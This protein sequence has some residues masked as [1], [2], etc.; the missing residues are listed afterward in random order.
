MRY[1][2]IT[3]TKD[4]SD[5]MAVADPLDVLFVKGDEVNR[6]L[7]ANLLSKYVRLDEK[8]RIFPLS[9]FYAETNKNK[10]IIILLSRK[11]ISLKSGKEEAASPSELSNVID[12]P[13]GSLRP[14]LRELVEEGIADDESSKYK[15]FSHTIQRCSE[16][17]TKKEPSETPIILRKQGSFPKTSMSAAIEDII[18]QG[19]LD[20]AKT[21]REVHEMVV[22]R[23]PGTLYNA[24]YKVILD[25]VSKQKIAREIKGDTWVYRRADK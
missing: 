3:V 24:L 6:E 8:G 11:A 4:V 15:I 16:M 25:F 12:I 10:V 13:D 19:G 9:S 14:V 18:R 17:L 22:Q 7:L 5:N 23:R 2:T 21:A 20:D 1:K